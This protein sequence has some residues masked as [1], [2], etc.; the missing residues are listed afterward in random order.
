MKK[1]FFMLAVCLLIMTGCSKD[2]MTNVMEGKN[3]VI[4]ATIEQSSPITRLSIA[5][6]NTLSWES[7]DAF[8]VFTDG[9]GKCYYK[10]DE[11]G[12]N[13]IVYDEGEG[14]PDEATVIGAAYPYDAAS[15]IYQ[16]NLSDNVLEMTLP[17]SY[18]DCEGGKCA[19]PM[20]GAWTDGNVSFKHLAGVLR[21]NL[22]NLPVG[23][24]A[25]TITA[26]NPIAGAFTANINDATPVLVAAA[27]GVTNTVT[28]NFTATTSEVK[29]KTLYLPL[30]LGDYEA[31]MVAVSD[32]TNNYVLANWSN[33]TVERATIYTAN[34]TYTEVT[35]I[36][37]LN[38]ALAAISDENR[39]AHIVVT[40]EI[41]GE[42]TITGPNLEGTSITLDFGNNVAAG[43]DLTINAPKSTVELGSGTFA[44]VTATTAENTL[45]IGEDVTI[46]TLTIAKGNVMVFGGNITTIVNNS[47]ESTVTYEVLT[48]DELKDAIG[49]GDYIILGDNIS[50]TDKICFESATNIDLGGFTLTENLGMESDYPIYIKGDVSISNG[51]IVTN[52][53]YPILIDN[54]ERI[55]D[56]SINNVAIDADR[57]ENNYN[58]AVILVGNADVEL[59]N[60]EIDAT[61]YSCAL[62]SSTY[63]VAGEKSAT[64]NISNSNFSLVNNDQLNS[65]AVLGAGHGSTINFESGT[66]DGLGASN[67]VVAFPTGG[68]V[69]IAAGE[70]KGKLYA[71]DAYNVEL[72]PTIISIKGGTFDQEPDG[73][74]VSSGYKVV[75]SEGEYT[76]V[77]DTESN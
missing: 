40:G 60:I 47:Q 65:Y 18:D 39:N 38:T 25:M 55:E 19:L 4:T 49:K 17:A 10:Y 71:Y 16:P 23:C 35:T 69:N 44:S 67:A 20:W 5:G 34:A 62:E 66:I 37:D 46:G 14:V 43:T 32:G 56:V 9:S 13:F 12:S 41:S 30:P 58:G 1:L 61:N 48:F 51:K 21:V 8:T 76:V 68:T 64:V 75:E 6:D 59:S 3:G 74:Y 7:E 11:S 36:A 52:S 50:L 53:R 22:N 31:I 24:C 73:K 45:I 63:D 77:V 70:I 15:T 28:L 2:E 57:K 27:E 72:W 26:S 29:N 42:Q 33:K 54:V